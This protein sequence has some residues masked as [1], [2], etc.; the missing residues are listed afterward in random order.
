MGSD[1]ADL[2]VSDGLSQR[3]R[4]LNL[5]GSVTESVRLSIATDDDRT[6]S[7]PTVRDARTNAGPLAGLEAAFREAPACAWLVIACD[8]PLLTESVLRVLANER[9]PRVDATCFTSRFDGKPEPLCAIYEPSAAPKLAAALDRDLR[10]VRKFL[11]SLDRKE[12]VLAEANALDNCNRPEDLAEAR[13]SLA[14]GRQDKTV[15]VEYCGPLREQ[16]GVSSEEIRTEAA[17]AAG[18]W[19]ELRMARDFS[20]ELD[21]LRVAINDEFQPWTHPLQSND[22]VALFPPFAGG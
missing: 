15:T 21:A 8:L 3:E 20:L 14:H 9:D 6:Y 18:L 22:R 12:V 7:I 16:A 1:K 11:G 17:T 5:L 4:G 13:L 10:C 2:V 19:E